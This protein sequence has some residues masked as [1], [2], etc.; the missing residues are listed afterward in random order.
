MA[1]R[2]SNPRDLTKTLAKGRNVRLMNV[3]G[4]WRLIGAAGSDLF[5]LAE[6][7]DAGGVPTGVVHNQLTQADLF[8]RRTVDDRTYTVSA[9]GGSVEMNSARGYA[10]T[11]A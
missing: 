10:Q 8:G 5:F 3:G 9:H 11:T 7:A 6:V 4:T 1:T 2:Q